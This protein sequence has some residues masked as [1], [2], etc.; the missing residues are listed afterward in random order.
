MTV[1]DDYTRPS[2]FG[3]PCRTLILEHR[4]KVYE[5]AHYPGH[6]DNMAWGT[7][8]RDDTGRKIKHTSETGQAV[9]SAARAHVAEGVAA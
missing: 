3:D 1:I 9:L 4:N 6:H 8:Y 2:Q 7:I 5:I